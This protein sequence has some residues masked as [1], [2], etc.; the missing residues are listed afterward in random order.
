MLSAETGEFLSTELF[1][2]H[3]SRFTPH[4][5]RQ[6]AIRHQL[7]ALFPN[8]IRFTNDEIPNSRQGACPILPSY[9]GERGAARCEAAGPKKPE[10]YS[11]QYGE[12]FVRP[13]TTQMVAN[14]SPQ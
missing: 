1:A 9:R 14:R 6:N 5:L 10:A 8:E 11:L 3:Y 2:T 4:P 12:V 13:K 7:S